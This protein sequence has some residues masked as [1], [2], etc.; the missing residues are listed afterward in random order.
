MKPFA[1]ACEQNRDPIL[2]VIGPLLAECRSV[3]EIGSGTGQH[4]VYFARH[5][6]HLVWHT[7]DLP[8]MHAGIR[9]WLEEAALPNTPPPISLDVQ[10]GSWP[11]L[12]I[13]GVFTANTTHIMPP[14][15]VQ[16]MFAGVAKLLEPGAP[17]L[18]YGPFMYGGKHTSESNE[19]FDRWIRAWE[20]HRGIRDLDWL[21]ELA[22]PLGLYLDED[23]AM[24]VNN[25]TLVWR[26]GADACG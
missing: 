23:I 1:E 17:F 14:E 18:I 7:S 21:L 3:L 5:M 25:R 2:T 4:A 11:R 20:P 12:S 15:A 10:A 9:V 22:Q 13:D 6:P 24:P 16:A 19:R 26:K 8:E